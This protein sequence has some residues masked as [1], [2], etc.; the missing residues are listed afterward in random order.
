[1]VSPKSVMKLQPFSCEFPVDY[2]QLSVF[3]SHAAFVWKQ[4][5]SIDESVT[6]H[7]SQ[8]SGGKGA[9]VSL[10]QVSAMRNCNVK[11]MLF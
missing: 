5:A 7:I 6:L 8:C 9:G 11:E 4:T 10:V 3:F 2:F 1:M